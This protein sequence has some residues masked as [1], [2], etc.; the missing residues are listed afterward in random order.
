MA[1]VFGF[2]HSAEAPTERI[3]STSV[4][5]SRMRGTL[6]SVT[7]WSVKRAAAM[8]GNAAFLLP[9]GVIVPA[10][11]WPPSTMYWIG[12]TRV[13]QMKSV[14]P[15]NPV[16]APKSTE[17]AGRAAQSYIAAQALSFPSPLWGGSASESEPGWGFEDHL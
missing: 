4:S 5:V 17:V 1:S 16:H 12:G 11:R 3:T 8:I 6:S 2:D 10:R 13:L 7:G 14:H 15:A 9:D